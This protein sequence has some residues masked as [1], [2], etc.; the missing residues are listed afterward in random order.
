MTTGSTT[1]GELG[2]NLMTASPPAGGAKKPSAF[3]RVVSQL[4]PRR[5]Y[6]INRRRQVRSALLVAVVVLLLL[7]PLNYSLHTVREQE[8]MTITA[9][10]PELKPLMLSRDRTELIVGLVASVVI[11]VGVFVLTIIE[12]HRT[13]GAAFALVRRLDEIGEGQYGT[14][15]TL[16]GGDNLREVEGP[17]NAMVDAL[18][19]R[20]IDEANELE[21]LARKANEIVVPQEAEAIAHRLRSLARKKR[22][23]AGLGTARKD[24]GTP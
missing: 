17:F 12:T 2:G 21:T 14:R 18:R 1:D 5:Q 7:M 23:Q 11:L 20:A 19:T 8:T 3:S 9:S 24:P 22:E 13:A 6:L 15:L 16:R 4:S 10:N